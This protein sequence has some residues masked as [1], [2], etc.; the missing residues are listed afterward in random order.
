[1]PCRVS[2]SPS[3]VGSPGTHGEHLDVLIVGAGISGIGAA[4]YLGRDHPERSVAILEARGDLG[5]TWDLFR[6]PGV[7]SDSDLYTF[8]Y[9]FKPWTG[10][11]AIA[12]GPSIHS[13]LRDVAAEFGIDKL[14]RYRHRV[15]SARWSTP[16]GYW[17]V[18]VDR[19][20]TGERIT[21]RCRWLFAA[22]GYYRYDGG[23][24]PSFPGHDRFT[25]TIVHPQQWPDDLDY[26][27]KRVVVIGSGATAV[28]LV[29]AM[30]QHAAHVT[31][32]QRTPTYILPVPSADRMAPKLRKWLGDER[33]H[34]WLR[35]RSIAQQ[36]ATWILARNYPQATRR[37]IRWTNKR[38]L[39]P[40]YPV[41]EHF[42]PPYAP[43][44]QRLCVV[45]DGDLFR[46]ISA[47]RASVITDRI[48]TF[49]ETGI[50][51]ESGD[52]IDAD[53]IV[54]ATGL[55][56]EPMA[57]LEMSVDG[58]PVVPRS[59]VAYKGFMLSGVPNF[60]YSVGYINASWT[61]KVGLLSEHLCR[62]FS[63]M[64]AQGFTVCVPETGSGMTST[65]PFLDFGA[66]YIQRAME[67]MP[68]QGDRWPWLTSMGY[69]DDVR[70][71][72][73]GR[74]AEPELHFSRG[75]VDGTKTS[76]GVSAVPVRRGE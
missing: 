36:R 58:E 30:A 15:V 54:T 70:L 31:M 63:Y 41:D 9:E 55:V 42:N 13:Y 64:D 20:D 28:T 44:D 18:D 48:R 47:G 2:D 46:A 43:W 34:V 17:Y 73:R 22:G 61:L 29:P 67:N 24:T 11:K 74:V 60:A 12:D 21:V 8:G 5:G 19:T 62:L 49:T 6:Y 38:S 14:I 23:Y 65:R 69:R 4:Y 53:I 39:P 32:L 66:G 45:P 76:T 1:L 10:P 68:R 72:R 59:T 35:R 27:G 40:G 50:A 57:G 33:A 37:F 51:L 16:D 26:A 7:R 75:P 25:G 71:L 56:L 3:P 52:H